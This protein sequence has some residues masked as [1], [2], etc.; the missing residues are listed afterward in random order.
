[1]GA[2]EVKHQHSVVRNGVLIVAP[3]GPLRYGLRALL[4]SIPNLE[5]VGVV[6]CT[7]EAV[8]AVSECQP[9]V[10]LLDGALPGEG[11]LTLLKSL[12]ARWP[13]LQ[14][15]ALVDGVEQ[16][17]QAQAGEA[18]MVLPKGVLAARLSAAVERLLTQ[19]GQVQRAATTGD[20]AQSTASRKPLDHERKCK[21][22]E[23]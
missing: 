7:T 11:L 23:A 14:C 4:R 13:E 8:Q 5:I 10:V 22:D 19:A 16:Q 9:A 3:P 21:D 6:A 17:R 20:T 12:K 15:L 2:V 1:M 18:D